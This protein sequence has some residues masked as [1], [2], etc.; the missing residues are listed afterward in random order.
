[1]IHN[2]ISANWLKNIGL[3]L[4]FMVGLASIFASG[5]GSDGDSSAPQVVDVIS[6]SVIGSGG[7][8]GVEVSAG[9]QSATTDLNGFYELNNVPVPGGG[10]LVV[11]YEK[12][13]Y[14]T[15]QRTLPVEANKTYSLTANLLQYHYSEQMNADNEQSFDV[16]DPNNPTGDPLAQLSFPAGSLG[17]GNVTVNVAVGDPTTDEGRPTFP[18]DYMAAVASGA[19]ADT[20]LESIVFTEIT[21]YD[22]DGNEITEVNAPVTITLRLPASLQTVYSAGDTIEWW[23]YDEVDAV[24]IREDADPATP[25]TIDNASVIDQGGVL[26]ARAKVTHFTWWNVDRPLNEHACLCATVVDG[27]GQPLAG[28]QLIAEGVTYNGRS[29]P[30]NTDSDG[31][32]CVTVKRSE[33]G[34][35]DRIRLFV[36]QGMVS[37]PYDVTS[38]NEGDVANNDIFTPT[39][40]GSTIANVGQCVDLTNNIVLSYDGRITGQVTFESSNT[41]VAGYVINSSF[42]ASATTD[43]NGNYELEVPVG[44]PVTLFA[45]GQMATT[46]TVVDENTPQVVNFEIANRAPVINHITR[47]PEGAVDNGQAVVLTASASDEDGDTLSYSWSAGQ[48]SFNTTSGASVTW[49]APAVGSGTA[50]LTVVV[51]DGKGGEVSQNIAI[52]YVGAVTGN[53]LSFI[54]KDDIESDQP[55]AGVVVALYNT[56]NQTIAQTLTSGADGVVDF[57][58][59]GRSRATFTIVYELVFQGYSSYEIESFI[60]MQ[61]AADIVYYRGLSDEGSAGSQTPVASVNYT[62]SEVPANAG[63]TSIMPTYGWWDFS[64]GSGLLSNRAVYEYQLQSDGTLSL[65]AETMG[66]FPNTDLFLAYG[67]LLDQTVTDGATY[68]IPLNRTPVT[69]GWSTEPST[70]LGRIEIEGFR[71]G[72]GYELASS[73]YGPGASGGLQVPTEFPV[74]YYRVRAESANWDSGFTSEKR[75]NTLPQSLVVPVPDYSFS[76]MAF[77]ETTNVVSWTLSGET[78][79]DFVEISMTFYGGMSGEESI[80][81]AVILAPDASDWQVMELPAPA[82]EWIDTT[83]LLNNVYGLRVEATDFDFVS[84]IDDLWQFFILGGSFEEAV[85]TELSGWESLT[86]GTDQFFKPDMQ[87][88]KS[89]AEVERADNGR[90]ARSPGFSKLHRQ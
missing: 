68:D 12:E 27:D 6:G 61:T 82:D 78:P 67:F 72:F 33:G 17:S 21:I 25:E 8:A 42:G 43:S 80:D 5:G 16:T 69:T 88:L 59:I 2:D 39:T 1:M 60:E 73:A 64:N 57:G 13:G 23:S 29:R 90:A 89:G 63:R 9:G 74:D 84:G 58:D 52:V 81:W 70:D 26:Y 41:P 53:S 56:D 7:I 49:S 48:G 65:L 19:V 75:Y 54:F 76:N 55:L 24:W 62:L 46:V 85:T 18:G 50:I 71:V 87:M 77:D 44:Q 28:V 3:V 22:A 31:Q 79:R 32:G 30:V 86:G 34:V 45:V 40:E 51:T 38:A 47:A 83:S 66:S 37:F 36:E 15:F 20:P 10:L 35:T 4:V 14:A 11:T